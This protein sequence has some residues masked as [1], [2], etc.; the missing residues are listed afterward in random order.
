VGD[1]S[2]AFVGIDTAKSRNAI[3]VA[4][5][6]R[7]GQVR[8]LGELDATAAATRKL[9]AKLAG[10]ERHTAANSSSTIRIS[11]C[12]AS[13]ARCR[14]MSVPRTSRGYWFASKVPEASI[15]RVL[16]PPWNGAQWCFSRGPSA[17]VAFVRSAPGRMPMRG[18]RGRPL[19]TSRRWRWPGWRKLTKGRQPHE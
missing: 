6:G 8:Y 15:M 14:S 10:M 4:D 3:A 5:D 12:G 9:V 18:Q 1:H 13:R 19:D 16:I 17:Y 11:K 2:Q 7:G